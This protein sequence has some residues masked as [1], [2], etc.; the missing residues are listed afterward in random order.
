MFLRPSESVSSL[1]VRG[2][3]VTRAELMVCFEAVLVEDMEQY[4]S[5]SVRG[6]E[7]MALSWSRGR[8]WMS[9]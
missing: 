8:C 2:E 3:E 5:C 9:S 1:R 7:V 6:L 4:L